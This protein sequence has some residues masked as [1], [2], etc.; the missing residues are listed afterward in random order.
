MFIYKYIFLQKDNK[1]ILLFLIL[2]LFLSNSNAQT[3]VSGGIY[4]NQ[5]WFK[6]KSPYL[7]NGKTVIFPNVKVTIEPGVTVMIDPSQS[8]EI[9]GLLMANG[10]LNDSINFVNNLDSIYS[11]SSPT[12]SLRRFSTS[13]FSFCQF[14]NLNTAIDLMDD[15]LKILIK[16]SSFI[17]NTN[18][19]IFR[20]NSLQLKVDSSIFIGNRN[21][22]V[23][24]SDPLSRIILNHCTFKRNKNG[25]IFGSSIVNNCSFGENQTGLTNLSVSQPSQNY[26]LSNSAFSYNS[27]YGIKQ[28]Y[29]SIRNCDFIENTLGVSYYPTATNSYFT[30]NTFSNNDTALVLTGRIQESTNYIRGN[31]ICDSY[32]LNVVN[33]VL[34]GSIDMTNNCWCLTDSSQIYNTILD[35]YNYYGYGL[36]K[37]IPCSYFCSYTTDNASFSS[38]T[39][40]L[41]IY[42]NPAS[43]EIKINNLIKNQP[44][45]SVELLDSYGN[46]IKEKFY[47]YNYPQ[48]EESIDIS[49]LA[50]GLYFIRVNYSGNMFN[51]SFIIQR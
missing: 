37:F 50:N 7:I 14:Q 11:T 44:L 10:S 36:V 6:A 8:F 4:T 43:S 42:P 27:V 2:L 12:I 30:G 40:T 45:T 9:R 31:E 1:L 19:I 13:E 47:D 29:G 39:A 24:A 46:Q 38:S 3:F 22:A 34:Y 41:T 32:G 26:S 17:K 15:S 21:S 51:T 18:G 23:E 28:G 33:Q 20:G 16:R 48:K 25:V 35:G 5:T 49:Y